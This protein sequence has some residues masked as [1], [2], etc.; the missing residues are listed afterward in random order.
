MSHED[1]ERVNANRIESITLAM[2]F[3]ILIGISASDDSKH[4]PLA[5]DEQDA[6]LTELM[7][8]ALLISWSGSAK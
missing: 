1:A 8:T 6:P 4:D 2:N 3:V 7:M 5:H